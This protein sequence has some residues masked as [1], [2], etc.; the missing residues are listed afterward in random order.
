M[1]IVNFKNVKE[2]KEVLGFAREMDGLGVVVVVPSANIKEVSEGTGLEGFSQHVDGFNDEEG[3]LGV[4][5]T[6]GAGASGT[7]LN[8]N[9]HPISLD[10]IKKAVK[11]C[12]GEGLKV[13]VCVKDLEMVGE[14]KELEVFA[15][16][17]EIPELIGTKDPITNYPDKVESFVKMFDGSKV[18]PLCGAG[19]NSLEDVEKAGELGCKG[20]LVSSAVMKAED[21]R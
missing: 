20:V 7:L 19:V 15:I 21:P 5:A 17:Y 16:A 1:I 14:L 2:G 18:D 10:E 3:F 12:H 13:V 9:D 4:K 8:H 11:E 6:K